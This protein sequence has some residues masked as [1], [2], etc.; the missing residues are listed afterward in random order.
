MIARRSFLVSGAAV[1]GGLGLAGLGISALRPATADAVEGG[2]AAVEGGTADLDPGSI[3]K[4][5]VR[6]PLP[7]VLAPYSVSGTTSYY[8]MTM[9]EV[10]AAILPGMPTTKVRTYNGK[11]PGP[12]IKARSGQRVV[13]EQTNGLG[14]PVSVH[15]HGA[16]VPES[17]DGG[18]MDLIQ[19]GGSKTYT[20]PNQQPHANLWFH[21]HAHHQESEH[22]Y[23]GLSGYYLLTDDTEQQLPLP[24]GQFDVSIALREAR[25]DQAGQLVYAM[26][27]WPN[28]N[29]ILVNGKPWP[30]FEVAARKYRLRVFNQSNGRFFDLKLSDGSEFTLIGGDGGLLAK[31]YRAT[32]VRLSPGERADIVVDFSRYPVGS[33][34][35]LE[36]GLGPGPV[37]HVGKVMRF[38]VTRTATDNSSVPST[39][40]TLPDLP[41]ATVNRRFD[42]SMDEDGR[43]DP[44]G[45]INGRTYDHHRVDTEIA[46]GSTEVWTVTNTNQLAPHNFHMHLVMFRVLERNG[47]PVTEGFETGLKDTVSILAGETVKLQATF[48]GYRGTYV[49]HCHLFDHS[50]MGMMGNFRVS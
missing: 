38:D 30:Y 3:A 17:S 46:Y 33:K 31:P 44:V 50:A 9:K 14:Q 40:R 27:D 43:P 8:R 1:S 45:Y 10:A 48:T 39:L 15:L 4:F 16:H 36:N 13:V 34:V 29:V 19:P 24:S 11:F 28:R 26:D 42:L 47:Q 18:P 6:M 32:V 20:Y 2:G 12:L 22:V 5:A 35:V 37:E 23:R 41:P 49:Y 25:F 21:D 7:P